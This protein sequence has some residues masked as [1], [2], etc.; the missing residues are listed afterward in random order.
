[1]SQLPERY[2]AAIAPLIDKAREFLEKGEALAPMAFVGN[3]T[4]GATIPA[5]LSMNSPAEKDAVAR[6]LKL[7]AE[8]L[9][10][11]F[12]FLLMEAY[13]LRADKVARYEEILDEYGSL[14][15]CPA[16]WRIDVVSLSLETRHGVWVAQVPVRPKGISKKKRTIGV[17]EFR[18]YTEVEGR[19]TDLLPVKEGEGGASGTLH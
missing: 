14:A 1:M 4:T 10:A 6:S 3:F 12:V 15:D 13:S 2:R 11:D 7:F 17:P 19:F 18:H 16:S 5:P 8:Q 9:D